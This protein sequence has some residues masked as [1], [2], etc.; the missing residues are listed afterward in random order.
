MDLT[1]DGCGEY[2][3]TL[4]AS[5]HMNRISNMIMWT[6]TRYMYMSKMT[7]NAAAGEEIKWHGSTAAST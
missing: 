7:E 6:C 1:T 4:H 2:K 5:N 3:A